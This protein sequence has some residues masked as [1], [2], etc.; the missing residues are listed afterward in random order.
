MTK[1]ARLKQ[2]AREAAKLR[3]HRLGRFRESVI[4]SETA[5]QSPRAAVVAVC[6]ICGSMAVVD[7]A[8]PPGE[9]EILGEAV[10]M[11]CLGIEREGHETA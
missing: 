5:P 1:L 10:E 11:Q 8:P 4:T 6:Q 3:G 9:P 7:P 2:E